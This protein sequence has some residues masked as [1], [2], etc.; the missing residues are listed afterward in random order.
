MSFRSV[1]DSVSGSVS[2]RPSRLEGNAEDGPR[3][4]N[5]SS[6]EHRHDC[7]RNAVAVDRLHSHSCDGADRENGRF[8]AGASDRRQCRFV[9]RHEHRRLRRENGVETAGDDRRVRIIGEHRLELLDG[10]DGIAR[11]RFTVHDADDG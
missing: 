7:V 3:A 1:P 8:D 5:G 9:D 4:V 11:I 6:L 10:L 2:A